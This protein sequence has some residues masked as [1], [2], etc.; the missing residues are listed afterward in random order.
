ME[1]RPGRKSR[2]SNNWDHMNTKELMA[3]MLPLTPQP[4]GGFWL[5]PHAVPYLFPERMR[6]LPTLQ[7]HTPAQRKPRATQFQQCSPV[8]TMLTRSAVA[9][10]FQILTSHTFMH[11]GLPQAAGSHHASSGA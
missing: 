6:P 3:L 10:Q 11:L 7:Q 1:H 9:L 2:S 5:Q 8:P 4:S